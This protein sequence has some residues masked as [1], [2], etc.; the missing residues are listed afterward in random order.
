MRVYFQLW[1][2]TYNI[3]IGR[4]WIAY[5]FRKYRIKWWNIGF[6]RIVPK[7]QMT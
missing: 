7:D 6:I 3:Q 5:R 2:A 4:L 1:I